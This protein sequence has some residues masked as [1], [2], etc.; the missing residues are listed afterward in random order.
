MVTAETLRRIIQCPN[1]N[2]P[3]ILF[4]LKD[5]HCDGCGEIYKKLP[6]SWSLIPGS[7]KSLDLIE[8]W[9]QLQEN[10]LISYQKDPHHNLSVGERQD[11]KDFAQ[12]CKFNG[13]VLDIGCGPQTWPAYF[14]FYSEK[15][16][17]IGVD[18]LVGEFPTKYP[19]FRAVG[20]FLPFATESF[21]HVLFATSLDHVIDPIKSLSEACRI[22][23][24]SGAIDIWISEKNPGA[25][26]PKTSHT[27]FEALEKPQK[28]DDV[29][30]FKRL[31]SNDLMSFFNKTG[32]QVIEEKISESDEYCTRLFYKVRGIE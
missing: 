21:D 1:C 18:P 16:H 4:Q 9:E 19:Q 11:C 14:R 31:N 28:A 7:F 17:F 30:H 23:K 12:F 2:S 24:R 20:E 8:S 22:T 27:W 32:L 29:F 15:T 3:L 6:H 10:G 5:A 13:L 25:P 26:K